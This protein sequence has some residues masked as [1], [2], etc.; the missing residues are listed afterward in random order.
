MGKR[1]DIQWADSAL[2]L[3]VGCDSPCEIAERCYARRLVE[4]FAGLSSAEGST[5]R[6]DHA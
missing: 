5:A 1:T 4:R 2:N 6:E 3:I